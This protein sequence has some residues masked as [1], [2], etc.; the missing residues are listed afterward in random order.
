VFL[1]Q[2]IGRIDAADVQTVLVERDITG[3][4]GEWGQMIE[5]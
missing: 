2:Q 4:Q 3:I 1:E 5:G